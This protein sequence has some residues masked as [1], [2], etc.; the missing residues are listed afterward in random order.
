MSPKSASVKAQTPPQDN[1]VF[2]EKSEKVD[3]VDKVEEDG[4]IVPQ[5]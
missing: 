1:E 2:A 5:S 3:K 4:Q